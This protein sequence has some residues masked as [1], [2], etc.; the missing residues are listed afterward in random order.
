MMMMIVVGG[1]NQ[2]PAQNESGESLSSNGMNNWGV[3][4]ERDG[5]IVLKKRPWTAAEDWVLAEY[6]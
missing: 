6:V 1:N 2:F 5:K 3:G 4:I